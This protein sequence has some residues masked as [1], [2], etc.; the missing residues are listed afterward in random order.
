MVDIHVLQTAVGGTWARTPKVV[1]RLA[2]KKGRALPQLELELELRHNTKPRHTVL[3]VRVVWDRVRP[4][5]WLIVLQKQL[6]SPYN[7]VRVLT[8]PHG[9]PRG[10]HIG[11]L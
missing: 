4:P 6:F 10:L 7:V 8:Y 5:R 9:G 11:A 3:D 2:L 1:M